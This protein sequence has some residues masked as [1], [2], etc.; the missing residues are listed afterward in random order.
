MGISKRGV[1]KP[2]SEGNS[3]SEGQQEGQERFNPSP[4]L[5]HPAQLQHLLET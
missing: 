5:H 2:T 3:A 4:C 1:L